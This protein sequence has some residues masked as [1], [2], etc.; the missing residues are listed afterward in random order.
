MVAWIWHAN[1]PRC[2]RAVPEGMKVLAWAPGCLQELISY[3]AWQRER[4]KFKV[5]RKLVFF[6]KNELW[7]VSPYQHRAGA[8]VPC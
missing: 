5:L 8:H 4:D 2:A 3:P 6:K 7:Q 1:P